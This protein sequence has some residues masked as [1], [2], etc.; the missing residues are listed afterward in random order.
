MRELKQVR[1]YTVLPKNQRGMLLVDVRALDPSTSRS[2][3]DREELCAILQE[4]ALF[5][6]LP[7]KMLREIA[8][9]ARPLSYE[10]G[11]VIYIRDE[12]AFD[13]YVVV[14]GAV[15]HEMPALG[16]VVTFVRYLGRG[17]VFGW[18]ALL[19]EN[20]ERLADTYCSERCELLLI[21]GDKL[22][23]M[24]AEDSQL[25]DDVMR[26]AATM[27]TREFGTMGNVA[28]RLRRPVKESATSSAGGR[29]GLWA[30]MRYRLYEWMRCANPWH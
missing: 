18:A 24:I 1:N 20:P 11:D 25:S 29:R 2:S 7:R 9:F 16:N 6:P 3:V 28:E 5:A 4:T 13:I 15:R 30:S 26:R 10:R 22:L 21:E 27:I 19:E 12:R 17:C 8:S 23:Q 14:S